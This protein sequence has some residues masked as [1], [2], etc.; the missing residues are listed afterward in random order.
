[1]EAGV[2]AGRLRSIPEVVAEPQTAARGM[3]RRLAYRP[4]QRNHG[5]GRGVQA[6]R[7]G[8]GPYCPA[9]PRRRRHHGNSRRA[10][11][12]SHPHRRTCIAGHRRDRGVAT[13]AIAMR[14]GRARS[15]RV[16]PAT[17]PRLRARPRQN[18]RSSRSPYCV[19]PSHCI[20]WKS[21]FMQQERVFVIAMKRRQEHIGAPG[22]RTGSSCYSA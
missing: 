11:L 10:G 19:R 22:C 7:R 14:G 13:G 12:Q 17:S 4:R 16:S 5:S 2:P 1:M 9:P 20:S 6:E 21:R 8:S 18:R 3:L 15:N